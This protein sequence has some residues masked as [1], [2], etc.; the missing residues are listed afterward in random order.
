MMK[1]LLIIAILFICGCGSYVET[2]PQVI[3]EIHA[4][5]PLNCSHEVNKGVN[6]WTFYAPC[7]KFN[8][9]DTIKITKL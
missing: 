9:G 3:R 4:T 7:G 1:K 2:T 8:V 5:S 6:S